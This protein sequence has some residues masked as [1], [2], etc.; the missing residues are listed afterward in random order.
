MPVFV[1]GWA[2]YANDKAQFQEIQLTAHWL[3]PLVDTNKKIQFLR[4]FKENYVKSLSEL[5]YRPALMKG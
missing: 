5:S 4:R 2:R 3:Q 1:L